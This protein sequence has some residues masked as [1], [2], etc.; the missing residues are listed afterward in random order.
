MTALFR[1]SCREA[2]RLLDQHA[3]RPLGIGQRL[4]LFW[5]L[6]IC[7]ACRAYRRHGEAIDLLMARREERAMPLDASAVEQV[8]LKR[9]SE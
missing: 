8:L 1:T 5:H 6:R 4:G 7:A 3:F 2:T 9:I